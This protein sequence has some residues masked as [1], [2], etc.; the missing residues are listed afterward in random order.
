M[1]RAGVLERREA[2]ICLEGLSE[3]DD[4]GHVFAEVGEIVA[5]QTVVKARTE[6]QTLSKEALDVRS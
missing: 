1:A 6:T 4:A 3:L 5:L 2:L